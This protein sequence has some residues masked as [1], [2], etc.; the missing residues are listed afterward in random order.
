MSN[1]QK[2]TECVELMNIIEFLED[3]SLVVVTDICNA[4]NSNKQYS[5]CSTVCNIYM[6]ELD[7]IFF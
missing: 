6:L 7:T 5:K 3:F 2:Q 1:C 4:I